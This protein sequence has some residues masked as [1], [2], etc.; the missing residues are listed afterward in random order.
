VIGCGIVAAI[1]G[2]LKKCFL[3][4]AVADDHQGGEAEATTTLD[5]L[6]DAVDRDDPL[7]VRGLLDGRVTAAA[8]T[9]VVAA[10]ATLGV[11]TAGLAATALLTRHGQSS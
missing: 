6:G 9:T 7:E 11:V 10:A 8:F 2:T 3:A 5:D 1:R 4:V